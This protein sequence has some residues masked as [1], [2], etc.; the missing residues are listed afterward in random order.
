MESLNYSTLM[1]FPIGIQSFSEIQGQ[2]SLSEQDSADMLN[3]RQ[4]LFLRAVPRRFGKG[5]LSTLELISLD[6][7]FVQGLISKSWKRWT[8]YPVL[9]ID[10]D[11]GRPLAGRGWK[12]C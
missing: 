6:K 12:L 8:V 4:I 5:L 1:L 2:L 3:F 7:R 9:H 11:F 10:A